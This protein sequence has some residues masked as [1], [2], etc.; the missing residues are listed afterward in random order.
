MDL[1]LFV[2]IVTYNRIE[3]LKKALKSYQEQS[4][5][6]QH[7]V[8]VNNN[9]TDGTTDFLKTW[10]AAADGFK[11]TVITTKQNIG[12]AGGFKLGMQYALEQGAGWI[13]VADD[14]AYPEKDA[15]SLID[16]YC[17][18]YLTEASCICGSVICNNFIDIDHRR[19]FSNSLIQ[20]PKRISRESYERETISIKETSF[21]GSCFKAEAIVKE[22]L[23]RDDFFIY[24]DD[25]EFSYR[26]VKR[27][28]ILLIPQIRI[29]HDTNTFSQHSNNDVATWRDYYLTRNHVYTLKINHKPT[30]IVYCM[31]KMMDMLSEYFKITNNKVLALKFNALKDGIIGNLGLHNIYKPGFT[32]NK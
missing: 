27:G 26:M 15:V 8:V 12:G 10:E 1:N 4:L 25:T 2:V 13:F 23:P 3:K 11:K 30:F 14:D 22:G 6:P 17:R 29:I 31:K 24:F 7:I 9:S 16:K 5:L 18:E 20:I 32:I 21:V 19:T 28:K